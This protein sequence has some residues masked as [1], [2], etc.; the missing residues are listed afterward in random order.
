MVM[1]G[2][3]LER[4]TLIA[5][6][7][8]LVLEGVSHR[9]A[10][11][12][13]LLVLPPPPVEGS[14]MD[15]VLGA[16][17]AWAVSHAGFPTLRFN[18]RGVGASQGALSRKPEDWLE[19]AQAALGLLRANVGGGPVAVAALGA[20]D[21]VALRLEGLVALA[22]VS[23]SIVRPE[24]LSP[25]G[26]A[27]AVVVAEHDARQPRPAWSQALEACGGT[28]HVVPSADRTFQRNLPLVGKAVVSLLEDC[29][30]NP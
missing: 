10:R 7:G 16:E 18:Y 1:A 8:G 15:H 12:P 21:A 20:S 25:G 14:G 26:P 13:G 27:L 22:L 11:A 23:P 3:F 9:G 2:Q 29:A 5:L 30:R 28:L 6:P 17:L 19:D 24:D 4:P